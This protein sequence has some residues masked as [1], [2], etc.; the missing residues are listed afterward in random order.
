MVFAHAV[1]ADAFGATGVPGVWVAG[2]VADPRAQVISSAAA[3]LNTAA[4]INADLI[5]ADIR[6]AV[7]VQRTAQAQEFWDGLY[8]ESVRNWSGRANAALVREVSDVAAGTVLD[9]GCGGGRGRGVARRAR[10]AGDRGRRLRRGTG[11]RRRARCRGRRD[12]HLGAP[13]PERRFS[14]GHLR[15]GERV[16]PALLP[17]ARPRGHP[18]A[19]GR[20]GRPCR[21]RSRCWRR[22]R[23]PTARGRCCAAPST[24]TR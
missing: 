18:P 16:V 22:W 19:C 11:A 14:G 12:G 9:L 2:N 5:A 21:H 23:C 4:A 8:G 20:G 13:R 6:D 17:A 10:V 3:G 1:P 24:T 7:A 15:P